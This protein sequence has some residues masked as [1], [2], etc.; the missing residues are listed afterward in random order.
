MDN[1]MRRNIIAVIDDDPSI[2]DALENM[3]S[4]FGYCTELYSSAEEFIHAA[5]TTEALCLVV[6]IQLGDISGVEL[7]RHLSAIGLT[8]PIIFITGS[9]DETTRR[10]ALDSGGVAYLHKPFSAEQ[11]ITAITSALSPRTQVCQ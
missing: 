7:A 3:L 9:R 5:I 10:Q 6:D 4:A 11:L 8:F 2:R 1:S